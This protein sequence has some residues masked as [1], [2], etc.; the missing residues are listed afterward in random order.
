VLVAAGADMMLSRNSWPHTDSGPRGNAMETAVAYGNAAT[1]KALLD[2]GWLAKG[3]KPLDCSAL[4]PAV[5]S[6]DLAKLDDLLA[7]GVP[8]TDDQ[9]SE[10]QRPMARV[11]SSGQSKTKWVKEDEN[12][13]RGVSMGTFYF[14]DCNV[15]VIKKLLAAGAPAEGT[16]LD[17]NMSMGIN[18]DGLSAVNPSYLGMA[19][20]DA[21]L[22]SAK[23]LIEAGAIITEEVKYCGL[24]CSGN[25]D[26]DNRPLVE[27]LLSKGVKAV[28][29]KPEQL[30]TMGDWGDSALLALLEV[31]AAVTELKMWTSPEEGKRGWTLLHCAARIGKL[32]LVTKMMAKGFDAAAKDA[33][34]LAATDSYS[35]TPG[36][37]IDGEMAVVLSG[38]DLEA[39]RAEEQA[40]KEAAEKAE[41]DEKAAKDAE[42]E[43]TGPGRLAKLLALVAPASGSAQ[44]YTMPESEEDPVAL[45][46]ELLGTDGGREAIG[47][48]SWG[49]KVKVPPTLLEFM[50]SAN[51]P[52]CMVWGNATRDVKGVKP[53]YGDDLPLVTVL[54]LLAAFNP[55][56]KPAELLKVVLDKC[57]VSLDGP[58][59]QWDSQDAS[60]YGEFGNTVTC[61][62][63]TSDGDKKCN[64]LTLFAELLKYAQ[65]NYQDSN[66]YDRPLSSSLPDFIR[67]LL[68][69]ENVYVEHDL[70]RRLGPT[71]P[72][73]WKEDIPK[74]Q[75]QRKDAMASSMDALA[76]SLVSL[77]YDGL[78]CGSD[79]AAKQFST[80]RLQLLAVL[81]AFGCGADSASAQAKKAEA[82]AHLAR[83]ATLMED[84]LKPPPLSDRVDAAVRK[85]AAGD[86]SDLLA[87]L[88]GP[89]GEAVL[90][91]DVAFD[92]QLAA[93]CPKKNLIYVLYAYSLMEKAGALEAMRLVL[94][95]PGGLELATSPLMMDMCPVYMLFFILVPQMYGMIA[96]MMGMD[97]DPVP[98]LELML[99]AG[100]D[101][102]AKI[103]QNPVNNPSTGDTLLMA[104]AHFAAIVDATPADSQAQF[105]NAREYT[106][107]AAKALVKHGADKNVKSSAA[108]YPDYNGKSIAEFAPA[109]F[110]EAIA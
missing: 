99:A 5:D 83:R 30:L 84:C 80:A 18:S 89:E 90:G 22:E 110:K 71:Y 46:S 108:A 1:M 77:T 78:T 57:L 109:W 44:T 52:S 66:K 42:F 60:L 95:K 45:L 91:L 54:C 34:G 19:C 101:P 81:S 74:W 64:D 21:D 82:E 2:G 6:G 61:I 32:E 98:G 39:Y 29:A 48:L 87:L 23:L 62:V 94:S 43:K 63:V 49:H 104:L 51:S 55:S 102:N 26:R 53:E 8:A 27:Y 7:L 56:S 15:A 69:H 58:P 38:R 40:K 97:K 93:W 37:T 33:A 12:T 59:D 13:T 76:D 106:I 9:L 73:S 68:A 11:W 75:Q 50:S 16:Y 47:P 4:N 25:S 100:A 92:C 67:V 20:R 28:D 36:W 31:P 88:N 14:R 24:V 103:P 107:G 41:A 85:L 65:R 86:A 3:G 35:P 17:S 105:G 96:A 10:G 79:S 72:E 70:K